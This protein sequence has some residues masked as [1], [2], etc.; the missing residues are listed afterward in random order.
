MSTLPLGIRKRVAD[1]LRRALITDQEGE[2]VASVH[3]LN[4]VLGAA[5]LNPHDLAELL[6][7]PP[8]DGQGDWRALVEKLLSE[9]VAR[10]TAWEFGFL[11]SIL[12]FRK[13]SPKQAAVLTNIGEV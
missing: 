7:L 13:L 10:L 4:R 8:D 11:E 5:G 3:A 9:Q 2:L 6:G 12:R 1:L